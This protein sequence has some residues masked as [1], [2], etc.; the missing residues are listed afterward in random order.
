MREARR[1]LAGSQVFSFL[2]LPSFRVEGSRVVLAGCLLARVVP[3][4]IRL[5]LARIRAPRPRRPRR[6]PCPHAAEPPNTPPLPPRPPNR[7]SQQRFLR[8]GKNGSSVAFRG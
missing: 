3:V 6:P 1:P 7:L 4:T 2:R 8:L 5:P